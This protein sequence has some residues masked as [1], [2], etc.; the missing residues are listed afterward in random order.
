VHSEYII[1]ESPHYALNGKVWSFGYGGTCALGHNNCESKSVPTLVA[2]GYEMTPNG[3]ELGGNMIVYSP[4][5][6]HHAALAIL[7][8]P[9]CTRHTALTILHSRY[10]TRDTALAILHSPYCTRHTALTIHHTPH[11]IG[12]TVRIVSVSAGHEHSLA[13][14]SNADLYR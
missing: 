12:P 9:Y 6:T 11:P 3:L 4:C 10:R 2:T 14:A 13:I 8:S 1:Y 7:H 5:C